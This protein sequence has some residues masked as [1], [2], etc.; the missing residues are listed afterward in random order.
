MMTRE[1]RSSAVIIGLDTYMIL[2]AVP[3]LR[4][5]TPQRLQS[6]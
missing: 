1:E 6:H 3:G 2:E 4:P 5:D